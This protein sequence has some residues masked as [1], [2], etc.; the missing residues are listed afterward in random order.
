MMQLKL[1]R[2]FVQATTDTACPDPF[3]T[4]DADGD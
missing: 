1:R 3:V 2:S 4:A